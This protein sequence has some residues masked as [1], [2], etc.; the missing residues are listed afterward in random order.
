MLFR[1]TPTF[2]ALPTWAEFFDSLPGYLKVPNPTDVD[3]AAWLKRIT[4]T[5]SKTRAVGLV[6]LLVEHAEVR[7]FDDVGVIRFN[8][9]ARSTSVGFGT[10]K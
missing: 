8:Q 1:G 3:L 2:R 7:G 10:F 6:H 4:P 9:A 5:S